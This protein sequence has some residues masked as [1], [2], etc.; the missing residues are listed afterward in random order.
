MA[1]DVLVAVLVVHGQRFNHALHILS[2]ELEQENSC[3]STG[4]FGMIVKRTFLLWLAMAR[5]PVVIRMVAST[6]ERRNEE[7]P[8]NISFS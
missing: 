1:W 4:H 5:T 3:V 8:L 7:W 6:A 2:H